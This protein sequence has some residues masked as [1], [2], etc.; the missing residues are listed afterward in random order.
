LFTNFSA[1]NTGI[2]HNTE[3]PY[4]IENLPDD[5]GYVANPAGPDFIDYGVGAFL[6][7]PLDTNRKFQ[8][9]AANFI[10]TFQVP[11]LR[12]VAALP[13]L[14]ATRTFMHNGFF[15]NLPLIVHFYN[16]RDV[17]PVCT[18]NTG[19]GVTC[20]PAPEVAANETSL[21]GNLGLSADDEAN[22]V[23]FLGTLTDG[24]TP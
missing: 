23:A 22:V 7:S 9:Q 3:V 13:A 12:N 17:L 6:A 21:I 2:P 15:S 4:L 16:T 5:N 14:G 20:W 10:G 18:G 8:A 24:Y 19:V 11:T 1:H